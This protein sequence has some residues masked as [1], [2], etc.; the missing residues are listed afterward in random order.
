MTMAKKYREPWEY[1]S[2]ID[3]F[4]VLRNRGCVYVDKTALMFQMARNGFIFLS[5]PRRF[6]KSLLCSTLKAYFQG[7]KDLFEG[8]AIEKLEQNWA[9]HTVFHF[10]MSVLKN[11]SQEDMRST[12]SFQLEANAEDNDL[13][14]PE[15]LTPG[16][17]FQKLVREA[18]KKTKT[19]VVIIIDEYDSALLHAQRNSEQ[20]DQIQQFLQEFYITCKNC[21]QYLR[22]VFITGITKFSQVSIFS[23]LKNLS[24][25]SMDQR[26][27]TICGITEQ[28]LHE[29][30]DDDIENLALSQNKTKQEMY[31][32][33][34]WKY[35]GFHFTEESEGVYNPY[36]LIRVLETQRLDSYWFASA[37]PSALFKLMKSFHPDVLKLNKTEYIKASS[38]NLSVHEM[39]TALPLLYQ[40]G[41]LTIK[42]FEQETLTYSLGIPNDEVRVGL[43][44]NFMQELTPMDTDQRG[45][46][47]VALNRALRKGDVDMAMNTLRSF[48]S[49]VPYL[50]NGNREI[51]KDIEKLEALHSRDLYILF[52]GMGLNLQTEVT[53][54]TGRVDLVVWVPDAIYIMEFKMRGTAMEALEQIDRNHYGAPYMADPRRKVKIGVRFEAT[55]HTIKDW[56]SIIVESALPSIFRT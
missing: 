36:S 31:D 24:N 25:I 9:K 43:F 37:T 22:H 50:Y 17:T 13:S 40:S 38:F 30:F 27:A 32:T 12:L 56:A 6:G 35:D 8:L 41:Y 44:E 11:K 2:G 34:K 5:R 55:E 46:M 48:L 33:L 18:Y 4:E 52:N 23:E 14:M 7:R 39:K 47:I 1:P 3:S 49:G 20:F 53:I 16:T 51:L 54:A 45:N 29:H 26:Y 15:G 21:G 28:E 10:D 19:G 42:D